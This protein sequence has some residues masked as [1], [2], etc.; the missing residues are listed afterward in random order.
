[1]TDRSWMEK[2]YNKMPGPQVL[3]GY[4]TER[5]ENKGYILWDL[6]FQNDKLLAN[7]P[8]IV[9]V[10]KKQVRPIVIDPVQAEN[11]IRQEEQNKFKKYQGL[12]NQL[13]QM[14]KVKSKIGPMSIGALGESDFSRLCL[15]L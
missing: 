3:M 9:V 12:K 1:M 4:T 14:Q 10:D 6:K 5:D 13:E 2:K 11:N 15:C 7:Q 8:D